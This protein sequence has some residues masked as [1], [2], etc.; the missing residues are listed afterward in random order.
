M[1]VETIQAQVPSVRSSRQLLLD[2]I[3]AQD[4]IVESPKI[5]TA[6]GIALAD[7]NGV[8]VR[9]LQ[10]VGTVA[11]FY[12]LDPTNNPSFN[13]MHGVLA[14]GTSNNDGTGGFVDLSRF[15]GTVRVG[16]AD[17][18]SAIRVATF[19]AKLNPDIKE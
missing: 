1:P 19:Q 5:V 7:E 11:V 16:P 10:N 15:R 2:A 17:G 4:L 8:A 6:A 3:R 9:T 12:V 14:A 18:S 13:N